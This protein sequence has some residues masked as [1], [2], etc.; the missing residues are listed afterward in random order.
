MPVKLKNSQ[1]ELLV[2]FPTENYQGPR[3]DHCGKIASLKYEGICLSGFET[4][5]KDADQNTGKAF[6]NEFGIDL[7]L[8]FENTPVGDWFHKIGVGLLKKT[9]SPYYFKNIYEVKPLSFEAEYSTTK[10]VMECTSPLLMGYAYKLK[11]EIELIESGF[12]INYYLEN[13]GNHEIIT[14]EYVHNFLLF[15]NQSIG[16]DYQLNF[17]FEIKPELFIETVNP[18]NKVIIGKDTIM[19]H[20]APNRDF[21]FSNLSGNELVMAQWTLINKKL[22]LG[23]SETGDFKTNAINLWGV[24]HVICPELFLHISLKPKE[25]KE[26]SRTYSVFKL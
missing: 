24:P 14:N 11:K 20:A 17:P 3:F 19:F 26:W 8:N 23:M 5:N 4:G 21:F 22:N 18:E 16:T 25:F 6:Y 9:N 10:I 7:P 13:I 12:K 2:D 1:I 15:N